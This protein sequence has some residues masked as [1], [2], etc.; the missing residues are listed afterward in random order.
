M[1]DDEAMTSH[2]DIVDYDEL[3]RVVFD[4]AVGDEEPVSETQTLTRK[5]EDGSIHETRRRRRPNIALAMKLLEDRI[6]GPQDY[7]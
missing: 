7:C 2:N 6:G 5:T 1:S 3:L 4:D